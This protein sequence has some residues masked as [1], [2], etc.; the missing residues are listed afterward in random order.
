MAKVV[1]KNEICKGL[2]KKNGPF[3]RFSGGHH[4]TY[5]WHNTEF[6][7]RAV[8][9]L[10][11]LYSRPLCKHSVCYLSLKE[12][13]IFYFFQKFRS[14]TCVCEIFVVPLQ[15]DLN[16]GTRNGSLARVKTCLYA[17]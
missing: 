9:S 5:A 7:K 12:V 16:E 4:G 17:D 15:R 14:K 10:L 1:K 8:P 11:V 6:L 2:A 3:P 13:E